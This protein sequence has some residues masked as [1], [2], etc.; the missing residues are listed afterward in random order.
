MLSKAKIYVGETLI[1]ELLGDPTTNP[2][3][4]ECDI[5]GRYVK[6]VSGREDNKLELTNVS[7][8]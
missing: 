8:Y 1:E 6:I 5:P 4:I 2:Y 3:I 7:V